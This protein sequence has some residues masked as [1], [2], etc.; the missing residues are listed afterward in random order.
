MDIRSF[1]FTLNGF[2]VRYADK[3]Q[4][5]VNCALSV[6]LSL[7]NEWV[8]STYTESSAYT[9]E[10]LRSIS[11]VGNGRRALPMPA[12]LR[13]VVPAELADMYQ[14]ILPKLAAFVQAMDSAQPIKQ[15]KG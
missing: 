2:G 10:T 9:G 7:G 5:A 4:R 3:S 15:G 14:S 6:R 8:V 12:S 1:S 11:F 13:R